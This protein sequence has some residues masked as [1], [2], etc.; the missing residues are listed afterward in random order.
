MVIIDAWQIEASSGTQIDDA[1]AE[2]VRTVVGQMLER[3]ALASVEQLATMG[4][5]ARVE[6]SQ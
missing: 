2:T 1:S 3:A 6:V 4:I 5:S